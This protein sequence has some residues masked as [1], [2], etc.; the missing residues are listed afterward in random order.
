MKGYRE[1]LAYIH[2]SGFGDY[3]RKAAPGLLRILARNRIGAG[4]VVDLGAVKQGW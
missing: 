3:A 1:D 4:L 2:D